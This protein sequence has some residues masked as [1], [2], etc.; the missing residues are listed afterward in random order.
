M[1]ATID[2]FFAFAASLLNSEASLRRGA[3]IGA[4]RARQSTPID[5]FFAFA[6]SMLNSEASLRLRRANRG[7]TRAR[8]A[9]QSTPID[10]FFAFAASLLNFEA[11]LR[12]RRANRGNMRRD[13][14]DNRRQSTFSSLSLLLSRILKLLLG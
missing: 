4:T 12:L 10:V 8:R 1:S 7:D 11:S 5:V 9:R 6:A 13:D 2:V 14:R 3:R